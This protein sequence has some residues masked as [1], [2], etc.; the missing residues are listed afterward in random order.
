MH[1]EATITYLFTFRQIFSS[2]FFFRYLGHKRSKKS[3]EKKH[4]QKKTFVNGWVGAHRTRVPI[5]RFCLQKA[6]NGVNNWT[7]V[8][9]T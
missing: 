7:F 5:F 4:K 8:M 6:K 9:K 2:R 3:G 1:D